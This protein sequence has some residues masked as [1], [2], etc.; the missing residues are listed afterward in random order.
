MVCGHVVEAREA[1]RGRRLIGK[2]LEVIRH[3]GVQ[4]DRRAVVIER[5]QLLSVVSHPAVAAEKPEFVP[6]DPAAEV[7]VEVAQRVKLLRASHARRAQGVVDIVGFESTRRPIH[8]R[9]AVKLVA[10]GLENGIDQQASPRH[11]R[12]AADRLDARPFDRVELHMA[13]PAAAGV[14]GGRQ[15]P[16]E[17]LPRFAQ[18]S[19]D[20]IDHPVGQARGADIQ[21]GA[22][23]GHLA[24]EGFEPIPAGRQD[25]QLLARQLGAGG[26]VRHIHQR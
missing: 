20:S 10:A 26:G 5:V 6:D 19:V 4:Q 15:H 16:F 13:A 9:V 18:L 22:Y 25:I 1:I 24:H 23:A 2:L 17:H 11:F 3:P 21:I 12:V 14:R 8:R 7:R